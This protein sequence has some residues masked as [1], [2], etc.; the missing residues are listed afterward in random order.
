[1]GGVGFLVWY[2]VTLEIRTVLVVQFDN[3][4]LN[5]ESLVC[6]IHVCFLVYMI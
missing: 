1:M 6:S 4:L 2:N 5:E 3:C